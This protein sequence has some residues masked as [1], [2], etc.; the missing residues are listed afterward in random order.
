MPITCHFSLNG[1]PSSLLQCYGIGSFPAFSGQKQGVNNASLTA[2]KNIGPLP[3]GRYYIV[4]R[5]S[6]GRLSELRDS[7]LRYGYGTNR[8]EWFA[9]YRAD[10]KIDDWTFINGVKR[11]NFRLHP[12]G[13]MG[14]SEGCI[15]LIH[16]SDFEYLRVQLLKTSMIPVPGSSLQA[17]G[18]IQVD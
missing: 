10:G 17:Y 14:L 15:T 1:M 4:G 7:F 6:G 2:V 9:L 3:Q 11:G 8:K 13:P 5:Q 18:T 12:V 16:I